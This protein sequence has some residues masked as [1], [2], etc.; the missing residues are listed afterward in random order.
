MNST[1]RKERK[2]EAQREETRA[3][4]GLMQLDVGWRRA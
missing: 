4:E 3:G 1:M 2:P